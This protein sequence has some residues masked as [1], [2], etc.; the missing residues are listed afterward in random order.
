MNF[1]YLSIILL[2][3]IGNQTNAKSIRTCSTNS[4]KTTQSKKSPVV[5]PKYQD[6]KVNP[7][8]AHTPKKFNFTTIQ[9]LSLSQLEQHY[10]LYNGYATKWNEI[11]QS[12]LTVDR[13]NVANIT[14]S[15]FRALKIAQTFALNGT[16]LHELYFGNLASNK[17]K[18]GPQ[19]LALLTEN[20]GS[21]ENFKTDLMACA[22]CS[23]GW[24][25]TSYQI[26]D[27]KAYNYVLDAHNETVPLLALPILI[28]DIYEHAYTID[29]GIQ[30]AEYLK[31]LWQ[32]INWDAVEERMLQWVNKFK[33][34]NTDK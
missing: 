20:W 3:V 15:P 7:V 31:V 32:T 29:F 5:K 19:T 6:S 4:P 16:I 17:S 18:P 23:R 8:Q 21:L 34:Y 11:E 30:R 25:V 26:L 22:S 13:S 12:L 9:G 24:V 33:V 14:Y 10:K 28:V 27:G 1:R 2:V